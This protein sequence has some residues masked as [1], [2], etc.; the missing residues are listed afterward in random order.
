MQTFNRRNRIAKITPTIAFAPKSVS[1]DDIDLC[2]DLF[3]AGS[4]ERQGE[5][6][7]RIRTE[8][9]QCDPF[10][11]VHGLHDAHGRYGTFALG[12]A[13]EAGSKWIS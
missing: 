7:V 5:R 4:I 12:V 2:V 3:H 9:T 1:A 8:T 11:S 10:A 13:S 6:L